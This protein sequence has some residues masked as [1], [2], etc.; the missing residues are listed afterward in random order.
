MKLRAWHLVA[1]ATIV[2]GCTR[3]LAEPEAFACPEVPVDDFRNVSAVL[4]KRCGSLD[5]HGQLARPLRIM[6]S[7]GLRL[8]TPSEFSDPSQAEE[9]GGI[10]GGLKATTEQE[11]EQNRLSLCGVEPERTE[12]VVI[13]NLEPTELMIIKKPSL[14]E[15][16]KGQQVFFKGGAGEECVASWLTGEVSIAD[17]VEA[18]QAP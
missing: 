1:L 8:F 2:I 5:C 6:G 16:H 7:T 4:E 13:G 15:R 18:L 12:Q 11:L 9:A 3:D 10:P 17:C 14:R